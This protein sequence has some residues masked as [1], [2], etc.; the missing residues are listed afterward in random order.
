MDKFLNQTLKYR[1]FL[2]LLTPQETGI[3]EYGKDPSPIRFEKIGTADVVT[4]LILIEAILVIFYWKNGQRGKY[5]LADAAASI[6]N[7]ALLTNLAVIGLFDIYLPVY[8]VVLD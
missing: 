6:A 3:Y 8:R 4:A 7:G 2:Y 1:V 5:N